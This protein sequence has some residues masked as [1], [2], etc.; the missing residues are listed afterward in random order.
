MARKPPQPVA[1]HDEPGRSALKQARDSN[2]NA[3]VVSC[4]H[5]ICGEVEEPRCRKADGSILRSLRRDR[6]ALSAGVGSNGDRR[7]SSRPRFASPGRRPAGSS[8]SVRLRK[9]PVSGRLDRSV[10]ADPA[11]RAARYPIHHCAHPRRFRDVRKGADGNHAGFRTF[12]H[13]Y[14]CDR[15]LS[16]RCFVSDCLLGSVREHLS[17]RRISLV[18]HSARGSRHILASSSVPGRTGRRG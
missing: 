7:R 10:E 6:S 5:A 4:G 2:S 16:L 18:R 14:R 9:F 11:G 13:S 3:P 12:R 17:P 8:H 15:F 1:T